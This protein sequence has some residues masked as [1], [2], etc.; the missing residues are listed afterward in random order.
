MKVAYTPLDIKFSIPEVNDVIKWFDANRI[1]E[2]DFWVFKDER[3]EWAIVACREQVQNWRSI[4][5][6]TKWIDSK[7]QMLP[8]TRLIF[9]P[10][11][12]KLFPELVTVIKKLPFKQIGVA[13]FLKQ[14]SNIEPHID[15][16]DLTKPNEPARY[17]IYITNHDENTF[18]METLSGQRLDIDIHPH[19]RAFAF[20]NVDFKHGAETPHKTKILLSVVGIL[21][22]DKHDELI[23]RSIRKF[24]D[25]VVID[26]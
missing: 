12:E 4:D 25:Y 10:G 3:H 19:Y 11:F 5:P 17:L 2:D 23:S 16:F 13:G 15:T 20:N 7:F 8:V 6:Y 1:Q 18:Y 26:Q 24:K 22:H 14:L 21:D 9:A